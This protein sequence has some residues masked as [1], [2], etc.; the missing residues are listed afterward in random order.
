MN[1][2]SDLCGDVLSAGCY[3]QHCHSVRAVTL[4]QGLKGPLKATKLWVR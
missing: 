3:I 4:L 2:M 1:S